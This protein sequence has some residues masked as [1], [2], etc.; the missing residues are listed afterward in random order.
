VDCLPS[1]NRWVQALRKSRQAVLESLIGAIRNM[2]WTEFRR[3][4]TVCGHRN[5]DSESR[6]AIAELSFLSRCVVG[7]NKIETSGNAMSH[8]A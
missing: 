7:V 4:F 3:A 6:R 1:L 2:N 5:L 8:A